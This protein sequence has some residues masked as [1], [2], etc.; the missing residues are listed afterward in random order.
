[1]ISI[2]KK[3][4]QWLFSFGQRRKILNFFDAQ[5]NIYSIYHKNT[6]RDEPN[7]WYEPQKKTATRPIASRPATVP[8]NQSGT[9][10]VVPVFDIKLR[11][12]E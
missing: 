4:D 8:T 12:V 5:P 9:R 10:P 3:K 11:Y 6:Y 2:I 7:P 1:M